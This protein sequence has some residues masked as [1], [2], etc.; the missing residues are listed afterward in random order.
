MQDS[1][2]AEQSSIIREALQTLAGLGARLDK[3][4][5]QRLLSGPYDERGARLTLSAGAGGVDAMDWTEMLERMY[6]RWVS[7]LGATRGGGHWSQGCMYTWW[8]WLSPRDTMI[9][10]YYHSTPC[11]GWPTRGGVTRVLVAVLHAL[12]AGWC[13]GR[14]LAS[15]IDSLLNA[16]ALSQF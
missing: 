12:C 11:Y 1:S 10:N 2:E 15:C 7:L 4:E 6:I 5:L 16:V 8:A 14:M 3:W 13:A 9:T